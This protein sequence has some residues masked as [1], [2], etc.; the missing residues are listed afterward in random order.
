MRAL[1]LILV[2]AAGLH[3]ADF[4][5]F[6]LGSTTA[7]RRGQ[8]QDFAFQLVQEG[9]TL[10]G[11]VYLDYGTTPILKGTVDGDTFTFQIVAREQDGNQINE[12]VLKFTGV[13][14]DGELEITR[15]REELRNAGNSG[16]SFSRAAKL[17]IKVK[18]VL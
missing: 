10:S 4:S 8:I 1:A 2:A 12:S 13:L 16:A 11:K 14:K 6:W 5:G 18:R 17:T 15:E 7:G 3:A 9:S